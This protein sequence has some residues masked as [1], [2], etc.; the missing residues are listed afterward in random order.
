MKMREYKS[1]RHYIGNH[2]RTL[3]IVGAI[4]LLGAVACAG[5]SARAKAVP[6]P[7]PAPFDALEGEKGEYVYLDV[8]GVSDWVY[9]YDE[10]TFYVLEDNWH[11]LYVGIL[12]EGQF[13]SLRAQNSYW[14]EL[15]DREIPVRLT[16]TA[17]NVTSS[18]KEAF[19]EVFEITGE[20]FDS[21]FG[22][23]SIDVGA[24][25]SGEKASMW[26]AFAVMLFVLSLIPLLGSR[27]NAAATRKALRRLENRGLLDT[28][29]AEF[30]S[31]LA[32]TVYKDRLRLTRR[33]LFGR[34]MG[35]AAAWE[36]VLWCYERVMRSYGIVV[37]ARILM[38]GTADG[39][40]HSLP[41]GPKDVDEL[42]KT[43]EKIG[44]RNPRLLR[45]FTKE[46]R[47]AWKAALRET[48]QSM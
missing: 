16:G 12:T 3:L 44:E 17:L 23:R 47:A 7:E 36:D 29:E 41:F 48:K 18:V 1:F 8:I 15:T 10:T 21:Y 38:I 42:Y 43:M 28:A 46:N 35:L 37:T 45:G 4:L 20:E 34:G 9:K 11:L 33:F 22:Y 39:R 19:S 2:T 25:P 31:P 14:N 5:L 40:L 13:A 32:E 27:P 26:S 24:T 30:A 6:L